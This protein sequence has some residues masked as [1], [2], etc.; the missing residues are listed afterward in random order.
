MCRSTR[1]WRVCCRTSSSRRPA[2]PSDPLQPT[3]RSQALEALRIAD[4]AAKAQAARA[5]DVRQGRSGAV[6]DLH[7]GSDIPGRPPRPLL[8]DP[9]SLKPRKPSTRE[10]RGALLHALAHIEF[11][12][13]DLALDAAFRFGGLP[14]DYYRDWLRVADEEALHFTLLRE[15]LRGLGYDYGDFPA[16]DGLWQMAERTRHDVLARIALVPRT[17]EAR[18]LDAAPP[19]RDKLAAAGDTRAA[20]ILDVILRDEVGHVAIGNR[21]YRWLCRERGLDPEVTY[22]RLAA[23]HR[24]PTLR[25]PFNVAARR[26][27]GFSDAEIAALVGDDGPAAP[28]ARGPTA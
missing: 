6:D 13:I 28:G 27:A 26:S 9:A 7:A 23:E 5:I 22:R 20:E 17:L 10:G 3:W 14:D 15:H 12:A 11:N 24:A 19:L 1:R 25:G 18:G 8:V 16:H 4:P 2:L 21:W